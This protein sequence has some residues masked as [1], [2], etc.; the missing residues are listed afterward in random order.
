MAHSQVVSVALP[1][2]HI[3]AERDTVAD[4]PITRPTLGLSEDSLRTLWLA[5]VAEGHVSLASPPRELP[6]FLTPSVWWVEPRVHMGH[7]I[8][9][10]GHECVGAPPHFLV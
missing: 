6:Y 8:G 7:V 4:V 1:S 2:T 9:G 10:W 5:D 3:L